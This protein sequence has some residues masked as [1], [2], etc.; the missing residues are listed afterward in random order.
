MVHTNLIHIYSKSIRKQYTGGTI[1]QNFVSPTCMTI[2]DFVIGWFEI[3][4]V[5][6]S[7]LSEVIAKNYKYI[8]KLSDRVSQLFINT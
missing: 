2:L 6:Y 5:P 8:E 3:F 1:F 7:D 4:R